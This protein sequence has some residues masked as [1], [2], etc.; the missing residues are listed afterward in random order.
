MF[1]KSV[2]NDEE[3]QNYNS[4]E[5]DEV[6]TVVGPSVVVEGDFVSEGDILVKGT[7]LGNVKTGRLLTVESGA[8]ILANIKAGEAII[9]GEVKGNVEIIGR[10]ELTESAKVLGDVKCKILA[11]AG[12]A[13]LQGQVNMVDLNSNS[14]KR[15]GRTK[16]VVNTEEVENEE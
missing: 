15:T 3:L 11:V 13:I 8:K 6:E 2:Q 10:L 12:G 16:K 1:Q 5:V 9:S 14:K 4:Q 7:V